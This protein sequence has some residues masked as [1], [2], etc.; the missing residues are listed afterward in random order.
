[1]NFKTLLMGSVATSALV[2]SA[3]PPEVIATNMADLA[4]LRY[5]AAQRLAVNAPKLAGL[6]EQAEAAADAQA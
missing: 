5:Q 3:T 2:L 4:Y 6:I 1:M